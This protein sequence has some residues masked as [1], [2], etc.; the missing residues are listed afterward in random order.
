M[1]KKSVLAAI[2]AAAIASVAVPA[3]ADT[4]NFDPDGTGGALPFVPID[5]LDWNT[6]NA[7]GVGVTTGTPGASFQ[8]YY[9]AN[10]GS[11]QTSGGATQF[12]NGGT[13]ADP[14]FFTLV[15]GFKETLTGVTVNTDGT[16]SLHFDFASG[17]NNFFEVLQNTTG[18]G[19]NLTGSC[20]VCGTDV[21]SGTI[22]PQGYSSGFTVVPPP[23]G[24]PL[25]P[26]DGA[27]GFNNYPGV[28]S[29]AGTGSVN[30]DASVG[31]VNSSFFQGIPL[32]DIINLAISTTTTTLPFNQIDPSACFFSTSTVGSGP[33]STT[34]ATATCNGAVFNGVTP[35]RGVGTVGAVNGVTGPNTMFEAHANTSFV[36]SAP[37][38]EPASMTLLGIGLLGAAAARRRQRKA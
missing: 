28:T 37:V 2:L 16:T 34:G 4:I 30:L 21:M 11:A 22:V 6:G 13:A 24:T 9:Q 15:V 32:G 25:P 5:N 19:S 23:A 8:L 10:L 12:N 7:I 1:L 38:P 26:L 17:G 36:E 27:G 35:F 31:F 33:G 18:I 29:L 3:A 14:S 20:F